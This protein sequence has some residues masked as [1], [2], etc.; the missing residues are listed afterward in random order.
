MEGFAVGGRD[1]RRAGE[2]LHLLRYATAAQH[3]AVSGLHIHADRVIAGGSVARDHKRL[4]PGAGHEVHAAAALH[5]VVGD[6]LVSRRQD[7]S[8]GVA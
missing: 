1:E 8:T 5:V 3:F 6:F 4:L 2:I 7:D